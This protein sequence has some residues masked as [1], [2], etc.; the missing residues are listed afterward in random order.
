VLTASETFA[1][2][3][4]TDNDL[5]STCL[6]QSL[7]DVHLDMFRVLAPDFELLSRTRLSDGG[8]QLWMYGIDTS[9]EY[10]QGPFRQVV[11]FRP[12]E[13]VRIPQKVEGPVAAGS[14]AAGKKKCTAAAA[15]D[16]DKGDGEWVSV[17]QATLWHWGRYYSFRRPPQTAEE[18]KR[19]STFW[20]PLV[21]DFGYVRESDGGAT[22][23][24][25]M[26][27]V[28]SRWKSRSGRLAWSLIG[29][30]VIAHEQAKWNLIGSMF[31]KLWGQGE[32]QRA[33]SGKEA[34]FAGETA[35]VLF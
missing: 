11:E 12:R 28:M 21:F 31:A 6:F 3:A 13:A 5:I 30:Q 34:A 14:L 23:R 15:A 22:D 26:R 25:T 24:V 9:T 16:D 19:M 29:R 27:C 1:V 7:P 18:N 35:A 8:V 32:G 4:Q 20:D 2:S 10:C 33:E 17:G